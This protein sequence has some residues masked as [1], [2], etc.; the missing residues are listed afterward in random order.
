M[1][2]ILPVNLTENQLLSRTLQFSLTF[3]GHH[4][5]IVKSVNFYAPRKLTYRDILLV[6]SLSV[7]AVIPTY[8]SNFIVTAIGTKKKKNNRD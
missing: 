2:H 7:Y 1:S 3:I 8:T 4:Q 5:Q 6:S